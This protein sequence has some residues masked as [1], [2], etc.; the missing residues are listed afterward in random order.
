VMSRL[1]GNKCCLLASLLVWSLLL[2]VRGASSFTRQCTINI[3]GEA[4]VRHAAACVPHI[5]LCRIARLPPA[6]CSTQLWALAVGL[7]GVSNPSE[8]TAEEAAANTTRLL[9][10]T[11]SRKQ[12]QYVDKLFTSLK[13]SCRGVGWS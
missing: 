7:Q 6:G 8:P 11:N 9:T 4:Q 1:A 3:D 12:L 13:S 5:S 10:T 2:C